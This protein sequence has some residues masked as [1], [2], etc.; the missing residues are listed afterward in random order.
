MR[1]VGDL[2]D[3]IGGVVV[4]DDAKGRPERGDEQA[5]DSGAGR[6]AERDEDRAD[7]SREQHGTHGTWR[8]WEAVSRTA[9]AYVRPVERYCRTPGLLTWCDNW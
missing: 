7:E 1:G 4:R 5:E 2:A 6:V 9:S 3:G 8:D